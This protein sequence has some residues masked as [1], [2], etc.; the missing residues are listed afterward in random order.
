MI[1]NQ[2]A[3]KRGSYYLNR[4]NLKAKDYMIKLGDYAVFE[5]DGKFVAETSMEEI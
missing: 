1:K 2:E 4:M 5:E 3:L